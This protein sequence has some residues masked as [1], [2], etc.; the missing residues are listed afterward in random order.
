MNKV[1]VLTILISFSV[2]TL[3][4]DTNTTEHNSSSIIDINA[5][6]EHNATLNKAQKVAKQLKEQIEKEKKI[7]KEQK[8]Y[9][10]DEYDLSSYKVD[11]S[12]LDSVPAIEPTYDFSMD[13]VYD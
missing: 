8:F 10:G 11:A 4:A 5:T 2:L 9:Q 3:F 7:A 12:S 13:H 1:L 6:V